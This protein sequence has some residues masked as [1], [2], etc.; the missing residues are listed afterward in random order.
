MA[1]LNSGILGG[2]SGTVGNV[3]GARWR[4]IDYIR[5]KPA[6][7]NNPNTEAQ[8]TQ[9]MRFRLVISLLRKIHPLVAAGFRGGGQT[10]TAMNQAMSVNIR[11]AITG[12][13]PDLQIDPEQLV[14]SRGDLYRA[15]APA[16]DLATAGTAA[17]SWQNN[18]G[19]SNASDT[20]GAMVLLYNQDLDEVVYRLNGATRA[21]ESLEVDIPA[22]WS[23]TTVAG[24]LAF[25]SETGRQTSDSQYL[26][27]QTAA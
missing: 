22:S 4:G 5:S 10:Q 13:F 14:V 3:V 23:G 24:Y 20:D 16:M 27:S 18:G 11:Q 7:V 12:I 17:I 1:K 6:T 25:R 21:D 19:T 9:R 2:I 26:G 8:Q 15:D